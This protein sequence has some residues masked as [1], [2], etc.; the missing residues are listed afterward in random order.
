MRPSRVS[1][2]SARGG[3]GD[4]GR[5][6]C[7]T[8]SDRSLAPPNTKRLTRALLDGAMLARSFPTNE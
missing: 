4:G 5:Y 2:A 7:K 8:S 1:V 3:G 6:F